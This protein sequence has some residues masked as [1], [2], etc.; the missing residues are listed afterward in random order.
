MPKIQEVKGKYTLSIP[1]DIAKLKGWK[2]GTV[3]EFK[4]QLGIITLIEIR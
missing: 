3:L 1:K 4:E 2:K